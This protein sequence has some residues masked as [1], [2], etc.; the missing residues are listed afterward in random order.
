MPPHNNNPR[1]Q[2]LLATL[3]LTIASLTSA[4]P[5]TSPQQSCLSDPACGPIPGSSPLY[6]TLTTLAPPWPGNTT[7]ATLNTTAALAAPDD[8]LFQNLLA[9]EWL[10]FAFYQQGVTRFTP[11]AFTAA[12]FPASTHARLLEIRNNEAGH[13]R[14]FQTHISPASVKPGPCSYSFPYDDADAASYLALQT[15][16]EVSS[17]AYLTGLALQASSAAAKAAL[18]AIAQVETR[19][20]TW[21]LIENWRSSPFVGPADTAFPYADQILDVTNAWI[22]PGSCPAA[23]PEYPFPRQGLPRLSVVGSGSNSNNVTS[24]QP[25]AEIVLSVQKNGD[26]HGGNSS[27]RV[28]TFDGAGRQYYA[29]FFHGL[30]NVSV[31]IELFSSS[32]S[33]SASASFRVTVPANLEAK[34]IFEVVLADEEGAPRAESVVAGPL[35]LLEDPAGLGLSLLG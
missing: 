23:N 3:A 10:V 24:V 9:A 17:M 2:W 32:A 7:G 29:V 11:Q 13:L 1:T 19:H 22:E 31:P 18:M 26:G 4:L 8:L 20:E 35:V 21:S 15:L 5:I 25:G 30:L 33:S 16:V 34:G 14:I 6:S 27:S 28:E 12:G